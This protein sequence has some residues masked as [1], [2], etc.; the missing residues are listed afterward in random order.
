MKIA[1]FISLM[2]LGVAIAI[3]FAMFNNWLY[4]EAY[5]GAMIY[6][7]CLTIGGLGLIF[8]TI[9]LLAIALKNYSS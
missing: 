7:G 1:L 8:S 4:F 3:L 9:C 2:V 6:L 5:A